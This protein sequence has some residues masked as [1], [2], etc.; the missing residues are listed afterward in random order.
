MRKPINLVEAWILLWIVLGL[1][2][3][4][5]CFSWTISSVQ[6][7][8]SYVDPSYEMVRDAGLTQMSQAEWNAQWP[9]ERAVYIEAALRKQTQ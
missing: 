2:S 3:A 1:V 7:Q 6:Q 9:S 5:V 8:K 4:L